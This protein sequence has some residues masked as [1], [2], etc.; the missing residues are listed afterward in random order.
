M[1]TFRDWILAVT[2]TALISSA[3]MALSPEGGAKRAVRFICGL[4]M[5]AALM[6]VAANLGGFGLK[7]Y[8]SRY[9][10][11]AEGYVEDAI[12]AGRRETRFI[13][14]RD[15]EA[16][17]LDKAAELGAEV[18]SVEVT[19]AWSDDGFW[20]PVSAVLEGDESDRLSRIIEA[21]LGI[22]RSEQIWRA[23][24]E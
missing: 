13:I 16:Y 6:S 14:E 22:G 1:E 8:A 17:I 20:Y 4:A 23:Y 21:D 12:D 15:C 11:E 18:R 3:A 5:M 24:G 2:G 7:E 9:T 19:A 10:L